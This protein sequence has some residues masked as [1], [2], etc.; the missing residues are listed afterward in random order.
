MERD[1]V[2]A[3]TAFAVP[4]KAVRSSLGFYANHMSTVESQQQWA[5][6]G[7]TYVLTLPLG[8]HASFRLGAQQNWHRRATG[9][10]G[11]PS[12]I[13]KPTSLDSLYTTTDF[14]AFI[15]RDHLLLGFSAESALN[16]PTRAYNILLG[17]RELRTSEFVKSSPFFA[18]SIL[19]DKDVPEF[20]FNYTITLGNT[21]N[22]GASVYRNTPFKF[23]MNTGFKLFNSLYLI[24]ALDYR[25]FKPLPDAVE[26]G[27][28]L[29][30]GKNRIRCDHEEFETYNRW[31]S[32]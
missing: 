28:R 14:G 3:Y 18:M 26:V 22:L 30:L 32:E 6:L 1:T 11:N 31:A 7:L 19:P 9:Q 17:F 10:I 21:F 15:K 12:D 20:K 5:D 13:W 16:K 2:M 8:R 23:G 29:N 24:G 4:I 27:L 25:E